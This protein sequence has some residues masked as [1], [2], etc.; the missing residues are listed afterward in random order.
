ML[1]LLSIICRASAR[2]EC[3]RL[4]HRARRGVRRPPRA[5]PESHSETHFEEVRASHA[6][7]CTH[8]HMLR[9]CARCHRSMCF[10]VCVDSTPRA[11]RRGGSNEREATRTMK[12]ARDS[13][14]RMRTQGCIGDECDLQR[15]RVHVS[16]RRTVEPS[17]VDARADGGGR[18]A[19]RSEDARAPSLSSRIDVSK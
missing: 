2:F 7:H 10:L 4:S 17:G 18:R 12:H 13:N 14:H 6:V 1:S 9:T 19:G 5:H 16:A 8:A 11:D 3:S 15:R